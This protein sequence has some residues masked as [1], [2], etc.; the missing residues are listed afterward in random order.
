VP[1][2]G[3]RSPNPTTFRVAM[4][5][6]VLV[7]IVLTGAIAINQVYNLEGTD[8]AGPGSPPP[9]IPT[10]INSEYRGEAGLYST[11]HLSLTEINSP[12]PYR[13][14]SGRLEIVCQ[15]SD[16]TVMKADLVNAAG[17][18][19]EETNDIW[20]RVIP[21]NYYVPAVYTTFPFG[22]EKMTPPDT[23]SGTTIPEC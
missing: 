23:P 12:P 5:V 15:V 9:V 2:G 10:Y 14:G 20:Y 3:P 11:P 1:V 6:A 13:V 22:V 16:G 7:V 8:P 19:R 21:S 4:L 18:E 17:V